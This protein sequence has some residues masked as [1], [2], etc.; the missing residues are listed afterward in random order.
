MSMTNRTGGGSG[1]TGP[2]R[3]GRSFRVV[4]LALAALLLTTLPA[5]AA[6]EALETDPRARSMGGAFTGVGGSY[7]AAYHNPAALSAVE[8]WQVGVSYVQPYGVGFLKLTTAGVSGRLPGRLGGFGL[9]FRRLGTSWRDQSLDEQ[10]TFTVAHG[11]ELLNDI[12]SRVSLGWALHLYSLSF[13]PTI[14]GA[15][16]GSATSVGLDFSGR[17]SLHNRTSVGFEAQNL[18]NPTIGDVDVEE[19]PRRVIGGVAY[20]PYAGVMTTFDLESQLG[21]KTRFRGGAEFEL[22]DFL[23]LRAGVATDP[24]VYSAGAGVK[25]HGMEFQ[26]GFSSGPGPLEESHQVALSVTPALLSREGE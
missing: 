9:G 26:Y 7:L 8:N 6:F 1:G 11:F 20:Q 18:N 10:N 17:V 24:G 23:A 22:T 14:T 19:L 4:P 2:G 15:D 25:W 3:I 16:P 12:S 5:R 21:E 13:G